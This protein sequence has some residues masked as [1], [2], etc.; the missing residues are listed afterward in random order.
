MSSV[1]ASNNRASLQ[2]RDQSAI[3]RGDMS[4]FVSRA[5]Q[6]LDHA[7]REFSLE[8]TGA[9]CADLGCSTGGFTD[10]LVQ[11]GAERVYAVDTG[12]GV[13]DYPLRKT[14]KVNAMEHITAMH[15]R[16]PKL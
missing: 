16:S 4:Q 10:C 6:K 3:L 8:I 5:G 13:F 11:R 15:V 7:V 9:V 14:P 1:V 2:N 12:Y